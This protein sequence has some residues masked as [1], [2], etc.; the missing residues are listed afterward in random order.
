[1]PP[2]CPLCGAQAATLLSEVQDYEYGALPDVHFEMWQCDACGH[3]R[4][5]PLPAPDQLDAIY[6][7]TYY[8]V[9]PR[10]PI[11]FPEFIYDVKMKRD[12]DRIVSLAAGR[13]VRSVVD[14]G[15]G[16]AERLAR[17][18]ESLGGGV[19]LIGV[20]FQPDEKRIVELEGRGV[21]LV[22]ADLESGLD[23]LE[24]GAH[25]L[26]IMC[27]II[28]HLRDPVG[29]LASVSRKL[30]PGGRVLLETP[31]I[32][33]VDF[34]LFRRRY[35]GAYHAPRHFHLF[36]RSTLERAASEAGLTVAKRG[37]IP[38]GFFIVSLRNALGL[39]SAERGRRFWEFLSMKNLAVV[40]AFSAFDLLWIALG[41]QTSNQFLLAEKPLA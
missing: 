2:P 37:F 4:L 31:N 38:S 23:V 10:S 25:D 33:G 19:E 1:M 22:R 18:G 36:T 15:C 39:T 27:Q 11:R 34:R 21:R 32:G 20:D 40:A 29:V 6:P 17:L 5:D 9:N 28:E 3:G 13:P 41:G 14:L 24:D 30:A 7:S 26:V 12:V 16:D 35:W 8:T